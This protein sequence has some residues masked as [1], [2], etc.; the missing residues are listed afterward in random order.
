MIF[1]PY[2]AVLW[3]NARQMKGENIEDTRLYCARSLILK[4]N[5]DGGPRYNKTIKVF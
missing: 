3:S 1:A 5:C 4:L 2:R